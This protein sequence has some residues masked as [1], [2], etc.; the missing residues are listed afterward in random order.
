MALDVITVPAISLECERLF[1]ATGLIV[2]PLRNCLD[3][4]I[5]RLIQTLRSWLREGIIE[6]VDSILLDDTA[7][8]EAIRRAYSE[9][10]Q[11]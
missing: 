11:E 8:E 4:G 9:E 6:D 3:A 5:I 1:S 2:T 10:H 7:L